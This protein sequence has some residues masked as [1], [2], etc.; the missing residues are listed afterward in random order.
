MASQAT[1]SGVRIP[2][3]APLWRLMDL[4]QLS[5]R[6]LRKTEITTFGLNMGHQFHLETKIITWSSR[7]GQALIMHCQVS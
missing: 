3:G 7:R 6:F 5:K 2:S 4:Y 1:L